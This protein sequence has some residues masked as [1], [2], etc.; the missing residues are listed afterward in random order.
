MTLLPGP[1]TRPAT[2]TAIAVLAVVGLVASLVALWPWLAGGPEREAGTAP[3]RA[4]SGPA[5][6]LQP[7]PD[8]RREGEVTRTDAGL[9]STPVSGPPPRPVAVRM[10]SID[11]RAPVRPVGVAGDGQME[12]PPDPRVLGWY[13]FGPE[14]GAGGGSAVLAGHLDSNRLGLGPLVRLRDAEVG[15]PVRV[16][17]AD[18]TTRTYT[19]RTVTRYDRQA[20][21]TR[22]FS[23][24]GPERLR[25]ITCG[26]AFDPEAG[27][28][29]QNLVVTA[30]PRGR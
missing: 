8:S 29:Q 24:G 9:A 18:G 1:G 5:A 15:D 21:P 28:Y 27:G 20:L 25:V 7:S 30:T 22:L 10:T 16:R 14:P 12:L 11:L 13:R 19:V 2:A 4:F 23:R 3:G 6:R 26:G 17:A